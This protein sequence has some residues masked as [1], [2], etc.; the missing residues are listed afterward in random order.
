MA[1]RAKA[2]ESPTVVVVVVVAFAVAVIR[3]TNKKECTFLFSFNRKS[4]R[5]VEHEENVMRLLVR[6]ANGARWSDRDE[7]DVGKFASF[8]VCE[9]RLLCFMR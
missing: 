8:V 1:N 4:V 7:C 2:G 9:N 6:N 3:P 5:I